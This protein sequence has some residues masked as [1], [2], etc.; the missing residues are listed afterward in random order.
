[1][2]LELIVFYFSV[3]DDNIEP[4]AKRLKMEPEDT[5]QTY[6]L[7]VGGTYTSV[8]FYISVNVGFAVSNAKGFILQ[9]VKFRTHYRNHSTKKQSMYLRIQQSHNQLK[10]NQK[11]YGNIQVGKSLSIIL[12]I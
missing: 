7:A 2:E 12:F 9:E 5:P 1:M 6:V 10:E 3:A 8:Q 4:L 11:R